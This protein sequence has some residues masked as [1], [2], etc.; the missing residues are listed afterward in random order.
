LY[1]GALFWSGRVLEALDRAEEAR[2]RFE[3]LV[4]EFPYDYYGLRARMHLRSGPAARTA[5]W[6]DDATNAA[7]K[8]AYRKSRFVTQVADA[9]FGFQRV[10]LAIGTG[11][12]ERAL[13]AEAELRMRT[14][15]RRLEEATLEELDAAGLLP[16]LVM[17]LALRQDALVA[18]RAAETPQARLALSHMVG[19]EV[20]DWSLSMLLVNG[21]GEPAD[22]R[23]AI[24]RHPAYL[25]TAFPEL[26]VA[27][28]EEAA[29]R[30]EAPPELL[31][32]VARRES[33]FYP[34]A[35]SSAG[36]IGLFQFMP[37]TFAALDRRWSLTDNA[38]ATT[39]SEYLMD[40]S[41]SIDLGGRWFGREQLP[42][43]GGDPLLAIMDHNA[44]YPAVRSWSRRWKQLGRSDDVEFMIETAR[45]VETRIFARGVI[46][47]MTIVR[48][49]GRFDRSERV[50]TD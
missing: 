12:Y 40:P 18:A 4:A 42:R 47:D 6:P 19:P 24:Q 48:S 10:Q 17:L 7:L 49:T 11:V 23:S 32:C 14:P 15:G 38:G 22:V 9:P 8:S 44:G 37:R 33:L 43:Y 35:L 20:G 3:R 16:R 46:G 41:R 21:T 30:W 31:Y 45:F 2:G 39:P 36:A 27:K 5:L 28:I 25:I 1:P 26:H 29:R 50:S 13:A 34:A